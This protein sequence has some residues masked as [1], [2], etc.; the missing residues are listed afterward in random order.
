MLL[1]FITHRHPEFW[2]SPETFDP[3][4]FTPENVAKRPRYAY[5]PFGGG[6]RLCIGREFALMEAQLILATLAQRYRLELLPGAKVL[7]LPLITM[8]PVGR[9]RMMLRERG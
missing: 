9:L 3:E 6:P 2:D 8:R 4:R 1:P 5:F 7:P